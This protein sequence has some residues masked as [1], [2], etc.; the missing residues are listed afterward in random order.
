MP[1]HHR[2]ISEWSSEKF[3]DWAG[4][5]GGHCKGYIIAILEKKQHPEQSYKS[6][7]G[8]LHLAKKYGRER[9]D[10]ACRRA[11]EY[12]AYNY[13]MVERILKKGWDLKK[14]MKRVPKTEYFIIIDRIN[15]I[16]V[17]L[18]P[19]QR[20]LFKMKLLMDLKG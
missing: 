1:S 5:I 10:G 17:N 3:I 13:N 9:L 2:F 7:L 14:E 8:V 16:L 11:A 12:G 19:N 15:L 4:N 20:K 18:S 6:C